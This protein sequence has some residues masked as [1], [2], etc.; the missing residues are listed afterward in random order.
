MEYPWLEIMNEFGEEVSSLVSM[1]DDN[2][3][4]TKIH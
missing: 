1:C 4:S 2:Y 3:K